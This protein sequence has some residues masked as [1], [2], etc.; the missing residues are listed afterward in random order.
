MGQGRQSLQN[1]GPVGSQGHSIPAL[2]L[3]SLGR[4]RPCSGLVDSS[5]KP[6]PR[7]RKQSCYRVS[8][9]ATG[10][11]CAKKI[12]LPS[13]V[14]RGVVTRVAGLGGPGLQEGLSSPPGPRPWRKAHCTEGGEAGAAEV[15]SGS[16]VLG[17]ALQDGPAPRALTSV[18]AAQV[19][20]QTQNLKATN[21]AEA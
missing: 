12:R 5:Q 7:Y 9:R 2:G 4:V 21:R 16:P 18:P 14:H 10:V 20:A 8:L 19:S 11:P 6:R 1:K 13:G 15:E 17:P 3:P